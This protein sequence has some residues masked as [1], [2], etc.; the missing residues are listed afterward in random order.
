MWQ[1]TWIELLCQ[2]NEK[3]LKV[4]WKVKGKQSNPKV[5]KNRKKWQGKKEFLVEADYCKAGWI[6]FFS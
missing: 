4:F 3:K 5:T 6:F 1:S 2:W